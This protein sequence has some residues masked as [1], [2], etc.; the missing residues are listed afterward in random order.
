MC[1][2]SAYAIQEFRFDNG[3]S[4]RECNGLWTNFAIPN[5]DC[6][7]IMPKGRIP[8]PSLVLLFM[9]MKQVRRL[10]YSFAR[11]GVYLSR[12]EYVL[13]YLYA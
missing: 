9:I 2:L 6:A 3:F 5:D 1:L 8:L 4:R 7:S 10:L 12:L 11:G 13:Y